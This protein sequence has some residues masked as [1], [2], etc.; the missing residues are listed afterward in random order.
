MK[1]EDIIVESW[2]SQS[3]AVCAITHKPTGIRIEGHDDR[4]P[5]SI[6]AAKKEAM[7]LLMDELEKLEQE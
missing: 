4:Y 5:G 7:Y 3:H 1:A 2:G 6:L